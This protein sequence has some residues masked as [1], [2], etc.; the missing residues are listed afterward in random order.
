MFEYIW[1]ATLRSDATQ[2]PSIKKIRCFIWPSIEV[3]ESGAPCA[4]HYTRAGFGNL[5][6]GD[7]WSFCLTAG[8]IGPRIRREHEQETAPEPYIGL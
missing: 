7:K 4:R 5:P 2:V 3:D 1:L 6:Q 8:K